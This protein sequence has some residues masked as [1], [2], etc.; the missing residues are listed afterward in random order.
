MKTDYINY[1]NLMN[2]FPHGVLF[3]DHVTLPMS[4]VY[5]FVC[6]TRRLGLNAHPVAF[7]QR[8]LAIV[9]PSE[10]E[11]IYIDVFES[12]TRPL[13]LY[14]DLVSILR[15]M[16]IDPA[17]AIAKKYFTPAS[18]AAILL[19]VVANIF[20]SLEGFTLWS[21]DGKAQRLAHYA[22]YSAALLL[23]GDPRLVRALFDIRPGGPLDCEVVLKQI[24]GPALPGAARQELDLYLMRRAELATHPL[25]KPPAEGQ[26]KAAYCAGMMFTQ[27]NDSYV[28]VIIGWNVGTTFI[29]RR[30]KM[31]TFIRL[32]LKQLKTG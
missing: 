10:G 17:S 9:I 32:N 18:T 12:D 30:L 29:L 11:S 4:L 27:K 16:G 19:R 1:H 25:P 21:E 20:R 15:G 14:P 3:E 2:H 23:T 7:P 31:D 26:Q 6:I 22:A 28:S 5:V 24:L 8:V 13:L